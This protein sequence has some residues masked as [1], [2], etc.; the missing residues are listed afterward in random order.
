MS[1]SSDPPDTQALLQSMLQRLKLHP[2]RE[3]Q[4]H[5]HTPVP[6]STASTWG[7]GGER[8]VSDFQ[9]V[10]NSSVNCFEFGTNCS[11]AKE[12]GISAA[13]GNGGEIQQRG[14]DFEMDRGLIS[15]STHK[16]STNGDTG[17]NRVLGQAAQPGINPTGT[18]QLFPVKS[19]K[20]ADITSF[21]MTDDKRVSLGSS[22]MSSHIPS[23][24]DAV[25][26]MGQNQDQDQGFPHKV[27]TWSLKPTDANLDIRSQENKVFHVGNGGFGAL[28]QSKDMQIVPTGQETT[29][30]SSRRK[31][32]SSENKTRRWTQKIKERWKDRQGKFGK[33]GKEE[34]W[35]ED[36]KIEQATKFSPQN[37]PMTE[38]NH[39]N[40]PNKEKESTLPSLHS[41]DSSKSPPTHF[42][43]GQGGQGYTRSG[44][45]FEI[46]LGSF[47]LLEEIV[48]GQEWAKFLNPNQS[49]TS[50]NQR[51]SEE[52]LSHLNIPANPHDSG[53]SSVILNQQGGVNNQWSFKG[54]EA[55]GVSNFSTAQTSPDTLQP[56]GMDITEEKQAGVQ[57]AQS[58]PM[59]HG[60]IRR[61]PSFA[62]PANIAIN[63]APKSR[64]QLNRKRQHQSAERLQ[65][66]DISDERPSSSLSLTS[67]HVME[68]GELHHDKVMPLYILNSSPPPLSSSP[69]TP[70]APVPRGVLKHSISQNSRELPE[71]SMEIM[72]KRR[73]VEENR[74]VRFSEEVETIALPEQDLDLTDSEEDS[75]ADEDSVIEQEF[76]VEQAAIE[77]VAPPRRTALPAWILG[78]KKRN[79]GRKHK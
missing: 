14:H 35:K 48:T 70:F 22:A 10:N 41:S 12:F 51:P 52:Q 37:Q 30:S 77:V 49:V 65:T 46:G 28:A 60:H 6:I 13:G 63:S 7:R 32:R 38:E 11:T 26:N 79:T 62:K 68:T 36:Q 42:E 74:R 47:S 72:T 45:D 25:T 67:S 69:S 15:F 40:T 18:G 71:S 44:S 58:E 75:G 76:E 54:T 4:A 53:Q 8:G 57:D 17:E 34:E 55:S 29:N 16:N 59:E 5:L 66:E 56:V 27:Y 19:L 1:Q 64:L 50:A 43:D 3:S 2:G 20:E 78:L 61:P 9:K 24:K 39:F 23:N 33:K 73:R 31:Q 21:K